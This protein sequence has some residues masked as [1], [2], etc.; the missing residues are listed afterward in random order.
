MKEMKK[1]TYIII[2]VISLFSCKKTEKSYYKTGELLSETTFITKDSYNI[3]IYYKNGNLKTTGKVYN[4]S[5]CTGVWNDYYEDGELRCQ[6][7]M[8]DGIATVSYENDTFPD[9]SKRDAYIRFSDNA[10]KH[11]NDEWRYLKGDVGRIP[12]RTY[13]EG[14]YNL[15]D[16]FYIVDCISRT[17][18]ASVEKIET[19]DRKNSYPYDLVIGETPDTILIRYLFCNEE[20]L[21]IRGVTPM[22]NFTVIVEE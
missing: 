2:L 12:F 16:S 3:K 20:G 4:D 11:K 15:H 13:V 22:T 1:T 10:E 5:L 14:V 18:T 19:E 21:I 8:E 7:V 17:G 9:L 6:Y